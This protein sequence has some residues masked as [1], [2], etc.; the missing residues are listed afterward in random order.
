MGQC[1][2]ASES[3]AAVLRGDRERQG[4]LGRGLLVGADCGA[5]DTAWQVSH[6]AAEPRRVTTNPLARGSG[7]GRSASVISRYRHPAAAAHR[8][9][10]AGEGG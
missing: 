6:Y 3:D 9:G 10:A 7:A 1:E 8:R 5:C 2:F 4:R